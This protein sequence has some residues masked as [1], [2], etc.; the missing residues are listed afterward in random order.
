MQKVLFLKGL[1]GS[2]K[3]TF[4]KDLIAKEPGVWKRVNKD[5]LRA[6]IDG[7]KWSRN[8][9]EFILL[10]R[11]MVVDHALR[12]GYSVIVDDTNFEEKHYTVIKEIAAHHK[13]VVEVNFFDTPIEVCVE[14]D[15]KR[16]APVGK[17][18][19]QRMY[20]QYLRVEVKP[21]PVDP[22]LPNAVLVDIDGTVA[23]MSGRGPF[24]WHRVDEDSPNQP[25]IDL[26]RILSDEYK[27]IF[28]SG[29]DEVCRNKTKTWLENVTRIFGAELFMRPENDNRKDAIVKR[30]LFDQYIRGK[31]NIS[32]VLDDR[33]QVVEM[34]RSLGLTC[35]QVAEGNF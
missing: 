30:E 27:I 31:Y 29:R 18:V 1:P 34:W 17:K 33:D 15:S 16:E 12:C 35:L 7:G 5:D 2:G 23:K 14:R 26:V 25:V 21:Y 28:F 11:N 20:N 8:N 32:L 22:K 9:E 6:M 19:I 4:A 3:S 10:M 24:D 13:T